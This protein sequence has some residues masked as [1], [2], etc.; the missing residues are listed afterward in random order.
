MEELGGPGCAQILK[1]LELGSPLAG[2]LAFAKQMT[3]GVM[4]RYLPPPPHSIRHLPRKG[5]GFFVFFSFLQ[6]F[7]FLHNLTRRVLCILYNVFC[8]GDNTLALCIVH[9][10]GNTFCA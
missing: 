5:G 1:E 7:Y 6:V 10:I 9:K 8:G 4:R 2:E 3:E